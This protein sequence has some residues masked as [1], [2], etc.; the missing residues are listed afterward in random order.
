MRY[1]LV[2]FDL[3]GTTL[4][5]VGDLTDGVNAALREKGMQERTEEEVLSFVGN[6]I[7]RMI[8]LAVPEGTEEQ[9]VDEVCA[10]FRAHYA[11]HCMDRTVPYEGVL[12]LLRDLKKAGIRTAVISNKDERLVSLLCGRLLEGQIDRSV[13][14]GG[15]YPRKPDPAG[16]LSVLETLGIPKEKTL[17][18]GDSPVDVKTA[19]NAGLQGVF[20][21]WGFSGGEKLRAMGVRVV[22]TA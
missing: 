18:V 1:E 8:S 9:T 3:D 13:G 21:S 14:S 20:V 4:N 16:T 17:Y 6:G 19:E 22:D 5:T 15:M 2:L 12:D 11:E 10:R 7:R